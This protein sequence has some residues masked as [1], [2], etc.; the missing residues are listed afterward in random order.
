MEL[1]IIGTAK[2]KDT[3]KAKRFFSD[4]GIHYHF[5][6]LNDKSLSPKEIANISRNDPE[7]LLDRE[8]KAWIE[9]GYEHRLFDAEE[10]LLENPALIKTPIIRNDKGVVIGFNQKALKNLL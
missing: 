2:C 3:A 10:E 4:R 6:D 1:Q 9:G 8:G 5:R 7:A